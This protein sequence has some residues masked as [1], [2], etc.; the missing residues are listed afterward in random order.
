MVK[1]IVLIFSFFLAFFTCVASI[2]NNT[3]NLKSI[4]KVKSIN[5]F[6]N[7]ECNFVIEEKS[8][9]HDARIKGGSI[10]DRIQ[11]SKIFAKELLPNLSSERIFEIV[12]N[13]K[14]LKK[15][16]D[17]EKFQD[18]NIHGIFKVEND[19]FHIFL[20]NCTDTEIE[21]TDDMLED[22]WAKHHEI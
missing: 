13:S 15:N 22:K 14:K 20:F 8:G 18:K 5:Y 2:K 7:N 21:C 19:E 16:H 10:K 9:M 12:L 1:F 11:C 3:D 4:T 6:K 17:M